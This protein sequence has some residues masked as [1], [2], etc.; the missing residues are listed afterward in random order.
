MNK[1]DGVAELVE[2]FALCWLHNTELGRAIRADM[3][4][5]QAVDAVF[6]ALNAGIL[7]LAKD[8]DGNLVG[9]TVRQVPEPPDRTVLRRGKRHH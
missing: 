3:T 4:V 6:E 5:D 8:E 7:K 9:F 2:Q 1:P